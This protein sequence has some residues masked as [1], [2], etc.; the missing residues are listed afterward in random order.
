MKLPICR[1][2][3]RRHDVRKRS[4]NGLDYV[5][6]GAETNSDG[7]TYYLCVHFLGPVPEPG[8]A[9]T[10]E[11]IRIEGGR[12][13]RHFHIGDDKLD[14]AGLVVAKDPEN[15]NREGCLK[16]PIQPLGDFSTYT[17]RLVEQDEAGNLKPLSGFDPRYASVTFSFRAHCPSNLDC[18]AEPDCPP[19]EYT[20]PE[21]DYL[22]KDFASFKRLILDRLSLIMP[23][24]QEKNPADLGITLVELLAYV[25]DY[26][27]YYQDAV[28]TEAYLETARQRISVRRHVRLVDYPM[29]EG[30]NARTWVWL[31]LFGREEFPLIPKDV[32][33]VTGFPNH[34]VEGTLLT[35]AD[36]PAGTGQTYQVFEPVAAR[37]D[38]PLEIYQAHNAI[39]FYTWGDRNCCLPK[40][41]TAA[42]LLDQWVFPA[43][44]P[45]PDHG[46]PQSPEQF[47][48]PPPQPLEP[49]RRLANLK[50]GQCLVF[51]EVRGATTGYPAD[52]DRR[53]RHV[54]RLT[55]VEPGEDDLYLQPD[56]LGPDTLPTPIV[57]IEWETADAL[58]FALCLSAIGP[59]PDCELIDNISLARGNV[60]LMDHGCTIA[61]EDLGRVPEKETIAPCEAEGQPAEVIQVPGRYRP[62]LQN[63]P[64]TFREP[65]DSA[66]L[67]TAP[68]TQLLHQ[69][70]R[71]AQPALTLVGKPSLLEAEPWWPQR[72]LMDSD[73]QDRHLVA[74]VDDQGQAYLRFGDGELGKAPTVGTQFSA[75]YRVGNGPSGNIG[76]DTLAFVVFRQTH[77]S[78]WRLEPHN[79]L[80]AVGGTAPE[81]L[82]DVKQLAP[83]AFRRQR[84]RAITAQDYADIVMERHPE[85]VQRATARLRW[86][87]SWY[88]VLGAIDPLGQ[89]EA[90]AAWLEAIAADLAAYRRLGHDVVIRSARYVPL[91]LELR[92]C[93]GPTCLRGQV[94]KAVRDRLSNRRLP[95]QTLGFFHPDNLTFGSPIAVSALVAAVRALPGVENVIVERLE[96][97]GEGD[98]G[99]LQQGVLS[100]GPL[101]V[102]R[103]DNDPNQP[104]N[105]EL[106]LTVE[107]GR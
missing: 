74:E 17:L 90:P 46:D 19:P 92:V 98:N 81:P 93:A 62:Q 70:P 22:A 54:V 89:E 21:I 73:G 96:R 2:E 59:A 97:L 3:Q 32:Y 20:E 78:G 36:L 63:A 53:H 71:L 24:W 79:P 48:P 107:G 33:V 91:T 57:D 82:M 18:N 72:D 25:G 102:A 88:E 105:G 100:L 42:T 41:T 85:R 37:P 94:E 35:P 55:R 101:E 38:S 13:I 34:P 56:P 86:T 58:P 14:D 67:D 1:T 26:L 77:E 5:E 83:Y 11:N 80:P 4:F 8:T 49:T 40:G 39:P 6:V 66:Q 43:E 31:E 68:A 9:I 60:L 30:C 15:S 28:A 95:D 45:S 23:Q 47:K 10:K 50:E 44:E 99:E 61:A 75:T 29:H 106:I 52:A 103:L 65:L 104:E 51:E 69:S 76:A 87:G 64:L 84:Q 16:I 27:S 12:R 7:K